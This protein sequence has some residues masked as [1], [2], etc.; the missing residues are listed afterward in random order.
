[1]IAAND[2]SRSDIGFGSE[3]NCVQLYF[4]DGNKKTVE[5][6]PKE[7]VAHA[8]LDEALALMEK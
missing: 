3:E 1:M 7:Q 4:A 5:K 2:I 6:C 8:I